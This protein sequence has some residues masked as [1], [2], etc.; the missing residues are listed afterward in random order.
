MEI[1]NTDMTV[2][3]SDIGM[4]WG[5]ILIS[6]MDELVAFQQQQPSSKRIIVKTQVSDLKSDVS[7][8]LISLN[9]SDFL[10]VH[11]LLTCVCE[12]ALHMPA[13]AASLGMLMCVH[14]ESRGHP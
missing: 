2:Y 14:V 10:C 4:S 3:A 11:V 1:V 7:F 9:C 8:N 12:C 5:T 6:R 13:Y